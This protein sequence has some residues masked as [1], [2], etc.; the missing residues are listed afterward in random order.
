MTEPT[1]KTVTHDH[2]FE[3][4]IAILIWGFIT[5]GHPFQNGDQQF[6]MD[7]DESPFQY[8]HPHIKMWI[9]I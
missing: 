7:I 4:V 5:H 8:G 6:A 2:Q 1:L 9:V 3:T